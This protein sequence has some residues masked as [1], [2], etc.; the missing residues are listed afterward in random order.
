[1][2]AIDTNVLLRYLLQDDREQ[3]AKADRLIRSNEAVLVSDVV[4]VETAWT[5]TGKRYRLDADAL[6]R[7]VRALFE[8]P[9]I[10]FQDSGA[11]WRALSDFV[12]A[13]A[14]GRDHA[15]GF[16][17]CLAVHAATSHAASAGAAF[18][19]FYTFDVAARRLPGTKG[20]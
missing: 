10:V 11:V 15:V 2:I 5:L 17:D 18:G 7:I 12:S 6:A 16:P 13:N 14:T 19:G 20:P 8:E 3:A 1:M 4:L 9:T